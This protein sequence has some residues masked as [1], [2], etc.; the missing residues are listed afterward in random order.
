MSLIQFIN[1]GLTPA[2]KKTN[3]EPV[4]LSQANTPHIQILTNVYDPLNNLTDYTKLITIPPINDGKTLFIYNANEYNAGYKGGIGS[5]SATIG[6]MEN[7]YGFFTGLLD[8]PIE[9]TS[10]TKQGFPSLSKF[11]RFQ[12]YPSGVTLKLNTSKMISGT[13]PRA[14]LD[15][16]FTDLRDTIKKKNY[17]RIILLLDNTGNLGSQVFNIG[18]DVKAHI[19]NNFAQLQP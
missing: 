17:T 3:A 7:T 14:L 16:L 5:A 8:K 19:I 9:D 13:T 4:I 12:N 2:L 18:D 6:C 11:S 10:E 1:L 15:N